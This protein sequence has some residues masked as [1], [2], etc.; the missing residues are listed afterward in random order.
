MFCVGALHEI[1]LTPI[2]SHMVGSPTNAED[3]VSTPTNVV[4][5]PVKV[6]RLPNG[7]GGVQ[8][9]TSEA[10]LGANGKRTLRALRLPELQQSMALLSKRGAILQA[11]TDD[12]YA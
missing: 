2:P 3:D 4:R 6:P 11:L 5:L 7:P 9:G 8:Q 10:Y 1:L 12:A